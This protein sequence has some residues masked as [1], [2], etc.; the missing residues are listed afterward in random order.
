[1]SSVRCWCEKKIDGFYYGVGHPSAAVSRPDHH[2][3]GAKLVGLTGAAID[4]LLQKFPYY[5]VA[6]SP[7]G[8]YAKSPAPDRDLRRDGHAGRQRL[9]APD[10]VVYNL[11]KATLDNFDEFKK[12]H[13]AFANLDPQQMI[14]AGLS[15]PLHPGAAEYDKEKGW[16]GAHRAQVRR[17][18]VFSLC[19]CRFLSRKG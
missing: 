5:S 4:A 9:V 19:E 1:M 2:L 11:V 16:L 17:W 10:E 14:K 7:G 12:L 6:K 3:L 15:A 8:T 18:P 13:P